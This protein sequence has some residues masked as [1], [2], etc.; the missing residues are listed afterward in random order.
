MLRAI[1]GIIV[2]Y[3]IFAVSAFL[4]FRLT[5]V[6][7]HAPASLSFEVLAIA[8]GVIFAMLGGYIGVAISRKLWVSPTIAI[9]IAAGAISSMVATGV[10]WSPIAALICMV[11]AALAGGWLRLRQYQP[12]DKGAN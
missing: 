4:L 12:N 1:A 5:H 10:N 2:G 7:P 3:L 6:D 11:P 8:F 9:I